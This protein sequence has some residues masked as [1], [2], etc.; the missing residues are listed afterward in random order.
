MV[1]CFIKKITGI[2]IRKNYITQFWYKYSDIL[3]AGYLK[4]INLSRKKADNIY[5]YSLY[6]DTLEAKIKEYNI[7]LGNTYNIDKKGFLINC[8]NNLY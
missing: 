6:F 4:P 2:D 3:V 8:L 5:L 7:Q 1:H